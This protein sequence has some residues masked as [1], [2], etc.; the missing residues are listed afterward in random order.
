MNYD[1]NLIFYVTWIYLRDIKNSLHFKCEFRNKWIKMIH[2]LKI[3]INKISNRIKIK[4]L[5]II[6]NTNLKY[7]GREILLI[8][9]LWFFDRILNNKKDN[10]YI[11][12]RLIRTTGLFKIPIRCGLSTINSICGGGGSCKI[13]TL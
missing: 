7:L 8:T 10:N 3:L 4:S 11:Y 13:L 12:L 9:D 2:F 6:I 5:I 1:E